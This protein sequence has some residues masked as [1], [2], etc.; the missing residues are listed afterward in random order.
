MADLGLAL[1]ALFCTW[2][3]DTGAYFAGR[4][5]GKHKLSGRDIAEEDRLKAP[6]VVF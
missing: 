3:G 4:S 6:W 5:L 1:A 2:A